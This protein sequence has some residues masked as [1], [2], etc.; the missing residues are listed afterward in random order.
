[1][2]RLDRVACLVTVTDAAYNYP[3]GLVDFKLSGCSGGVA[4][5]NITVAGTY[6]L[7]KVALRKYNPNTKTY[8]TIDRTNEDFSVVTTTLNNGPAI[9]VTYNINDGGP[10]DTDGAVDGN[11]SDPIGFGQ[12]VVNVPNTGLIR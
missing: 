11:I 7:D 12:L 4:T 2:F 8:T 10:F 9:K 6:D 5:V 1:M 3:A